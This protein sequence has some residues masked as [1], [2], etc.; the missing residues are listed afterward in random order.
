MVCLSKTT[1]VK[2]R[3][4]EKKWYTVVAP[5][6][7]GNV[8]I[9]KIPAMSPEALI[10]RVVETTLY[11]ITDDFSQQHVKLYFQ[12]INV[13]GDKAYTVF[14]GHDLARDYLRSLIRRGSS[15]VDGI[16]IATTRDNFEVQV[17]AISITEHRAKTSQEKEIRRIMQNI[18]EKKAEQLGFEEFVQQAVLGKI[19]SEI[20]NEAK[21]I[22][23]LRKVEVRKSE[24][25][26]R[27][28]EAIAAAV[29]SS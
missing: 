15:R 21:K 24:L 3:W 22:Y 26:R 6:A 7:F 2:D 9:G 28:A 5:A 8:E 29:S 1:R 13:E 17:A 18:I 27:P 20:Y 4:R 19:A 10:G 16:F 25:L 11:N 12:V 23:P 14:K